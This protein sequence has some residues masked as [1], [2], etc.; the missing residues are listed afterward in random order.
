[1]IVTL[2]YEKEELVTWGWAKTK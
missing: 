1:M 2:H